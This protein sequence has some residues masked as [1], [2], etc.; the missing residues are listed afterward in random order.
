MIYII[1]G[2]LIF[3]VILGVIL[4]DIPQGYDTEWKPSLWD[5]WTK[6]DKK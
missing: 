3:T 1:I 5:K 6:G 2:T 4:P